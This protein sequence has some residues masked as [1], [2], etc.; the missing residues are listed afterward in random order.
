MKIKYAEYVGPKE[1]KLFRPSVPII[2]KYSSKFVSTFALVD[3]GADY[4]IFQ[5]CSKVNIS[6]TKDVS[7]QLMINVIY[8]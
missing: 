1:E 2:L 7:F 3:S 8:L 6:I 5:Y 4:N